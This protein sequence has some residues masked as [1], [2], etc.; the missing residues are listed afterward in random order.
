[1]T[2]Q[3]LNQ[4]SPKQKTPKKKG[5]LR[6]EAIIP[7]IIVGAL[8]CAYFYLFFDS[9]LKTALELGGTYTHGAEV[10]I[11]AIKTNLSEGRLTIT[12]IQVTDKEHPEQNLIQIGQIDVALSWDALLRAKFVIP[13]ASIENIQASTI[14]QRPGRIIPKEESDK[15]G[16]K[17]ITE[18]QT[19]A[20][21]KMKK[22]YNTNILG[23]VASIVGGS[24]P[25]KQLEKIQSELTSEKKIK[26]L[27]QEI[28]L[29]EKIWK[30][31]FA[32]MPQKKE[33]DALIARGEK[34]KFKGNA[35]Q[36]AKDIEAADKILKEADQ[37]YKTYQKTQKELGSDYSQLEGGIQGID[38][39]IQKDIDDLQARLKIPSLNVK[40]FSK[41]LFGN[42]LMQK[43]GSYAKY[44]EMGKQYMPPPKDP[45]ATPD[46]ALTPPTRGKGLDIMFPITSGFPLFW[47]QKATISSKSAESKLSG[48]IKGELKN[49]TS[50]PQFLKKPMTLTVKGN[51][52]HQGIRGLDALLTVDHTTPNT[53]DSLAMTIAEFPVD[54]MV[55]SSGKEVKFAIKKAQGAN[56]RQCSF[57][58]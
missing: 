56:S 2:D 24:D 55:L 40:D 20:L 32:K 39:L 4:K 30:E 43:L 21:S 54:R 45:H 6:I 33:V 34:L 12:D 23:D 47:L 17:L 58:K 44:V 8:S 46:E 22:D 37:I 15:N 48:D 26:E 3:D 11:N 13:K 53:K 36:I 50:D 27:K 49:A 25:S 38:K 9:N 41:G 5:P 7:L 18:V 1:M 35:L 16:G 10:N 28:A 29:K 19:E 51:F 31:R 14:R 57:S 42:M 52:P